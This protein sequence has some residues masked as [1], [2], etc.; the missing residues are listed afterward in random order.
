MKVCVVGASEKL[1]LRQGPGA[2]HR[3]HGGIIP[4][5]LGH[6]VSLVRPTLGPRLVIDLT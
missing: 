6:V 4:R 5:R 2:R 1:E 3:Q